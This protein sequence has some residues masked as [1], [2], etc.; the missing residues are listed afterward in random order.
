MMKRIGAFALV[1]LLLL[2]CMQP[3]AAAT[4]GP[5]TTYAELAALAA[6]AADGDTLLVSGDLSADGEVLNLPRRVTLASSE[7]ERATIR[8]LALQDASIQI[9][10]I[11]LMDTLTIEGISYVELLGSVRVV[12]AAGDNGLRFSGSGAL[13]VD[14]SC[15]IT[16]GTTGAGL[17]ISHDGGDFYASLEGTVR[18][19][20]GSTG[21]PGVVVS[22]LEQSGAMMISGSIYG[23]DGSAIGGHALNLFELSGN[24]YITVD[25]SIQGGSGPVGGDGI[26]LVSAGD[27]VNVGIS[28]RVSGGA[29][30]EYGGDALILM[31]AGGASAVTLSG[32]LTGGD[33]VSQEGQPGT[34]LLI[35][36]ES[37]ALH[38]RVQDCLLEDG[39]KLTPTPA[40][41][42]EPNVTPLPAITSSL[43]DID[44]LTPRPTL[45]APTQSPAPSETPPSEAT[46]SEADRTQTDTAPDSTVQ[47]DE[48]SPGITDEDVPGTEDEETSAPADGNTTALLGEDSP[49]AGEDAPLAGEDAPLAGENAPLTDEDAPLTDEDAPLTDEDAF[50]AAP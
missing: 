25:G 15:E 48:D 7:G 11:D 31:N 24:A 32:A 10:G 12:G 22:P 47:P 16:G 13:I 2:G 3:A 4:L 26:Q 42:Q 14:S 49:L 36:G 34:S 6:Q 8:G 5:A 41:T 9:S 20:S 38:A 35:V 45:D 37:T 40:P 21:G 17:S 50:A 30:Q 23:G 19:G 33:T 44:R 18:G 39:R 29:G 28:G 27:Q 1:L 43:S 46:P